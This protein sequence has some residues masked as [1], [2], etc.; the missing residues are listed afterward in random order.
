M[1]HNYEYPVETE[2]GLIDI[3]SLCKQVKQSHYRPGVAQ[4]FPGS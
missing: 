3:I 4:W 1:N 2:L